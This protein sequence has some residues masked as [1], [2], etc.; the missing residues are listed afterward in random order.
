MRSGLI[1]EGSSHQHLN[2]VTRRLDETTDWYCCWGNGY[3]ARWMR[4]I[5]GELQAALAA[6]RNYEL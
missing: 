2:Q 5:Y 1:V 4:Y 3:V 6:G